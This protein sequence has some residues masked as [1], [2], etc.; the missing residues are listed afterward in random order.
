MK[1]KLTP[2]TGNLEDQIKA[3]KYDYVNSNITAEHFA[4]G[5]CAKEVTLFEIGKTMTTAEI[6]KLMDIQ[7][8]RPATL[9]ELLAF[10]AQYPDEQRKYWLIVALGSG[11]VDPDGYRDVPY[12]G[13]SGSKRNLSLNWDNPDDG[14]Y[15][16]C[17]FLAVSKSLDT[18]NFG[19]S[20]GNL[21]SR[22]LALEN[23]KSKVEKILKVE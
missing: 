3:G 15:G 17:R 22:I 12:L 21:E 6:E 1:F 13:G 2:L 19:A 5:E 20:L 23:F 16:R 7:D 4:L 11:W 8:L 18:G 14:W 9:T 10:G